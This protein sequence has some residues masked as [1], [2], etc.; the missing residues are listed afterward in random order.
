MPPDRVFELRNYLLRPGQRDVLIDL[1]EREFIESQETLGAHVVGAF[2]D[3]DRPDH[4]VWI[5]GFADFASRLAA[6]DGFYA[7]PVWQAHRMEANATMLDTGNVL[8]LRPLS[9]SLARAPHARPP[10]GAA[11]SPG[12][13]FVVATYFVEAGG[14]RAFAAAFDREIAPRIREGGGELIATLATEPGANNYPRLPVREDVNVL[15]AVA[16]YQRLDAFAAWPRGAS[17]EGRLSAP[18]EIMRLQP[19]PR[20]LLR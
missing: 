20:S 13:L 17:L 6:L 11:S 4:F 14:E 3:L 5:R 15:V 9:G 16:R 10:V 8:L 7:G 2:R 18:T 1:F 19:T 12:S